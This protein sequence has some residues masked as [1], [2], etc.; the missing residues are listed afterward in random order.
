MTFQL[1]L[2]GKTALVTGATRGIGAAIARDFAVLGAN[3]I[4]TGTN[5]AQIVELNR[6]SEQAGIHNIRY[7]QADFADRESLQAFLGEIACYDKIDI[8]INNAGTNR[9]L[10][11]YEVTAQDYDFLADVNLRAPFLICREVSQMMKRSG[12]GRIVNIASIWS[13]VT[14]A[15]RSI[16]TTTKFGLVGMTK[17]LAV[18]LAPFNVLVNAVSPGFTM[19]ELTK[20]SLSDEQIRE[21]AEQVPLNRFAQ[22]EEIAKAVLFLASD[23]NTY[24]T[25]QNIV[26]DGGFVSV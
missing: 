7:V 1:D 22:P 3:L 25:G 6:T 19:T 26:V 21:L 17:T 10:P 18:D 8:C 4:L 20:A 24:I 15:K 13:V 9:I 5:P 23:L 14:K 2:S 11:I 16:Y 12:Y